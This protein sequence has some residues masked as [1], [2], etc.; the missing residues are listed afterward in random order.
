MFS[1]QRQ[2]AVRF[3]IL[4]ILDRKLV[5]SQLITSG[6]ITMPKIVTYTNQTYILMFRYYSNIIFVKLWFSIPAIMRKV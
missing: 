6:L 4:V 5:N 3:N 1:K 2:N